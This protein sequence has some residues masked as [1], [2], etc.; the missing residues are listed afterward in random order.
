MRSLRVG[1]ATD[2]ATMVGPLIAPPSGPL[3]RALTELD[4][5]ESWLVEPRQLDDSGRLWS[6]GV[7]LGRAARIVV[8]P[9]PSA[10]A[11]SSA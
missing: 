9:A 6:P 5:G 7:R 11:R 10:S 2:L 4:D 3:A 8:P 1:P